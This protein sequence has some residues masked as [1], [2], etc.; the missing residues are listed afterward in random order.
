MVDTTLSE[1]EVDR[2][3]NAHHAHIMDFDIPIKSLVK[4]LLRAK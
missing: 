2:V 1:F 3:L 4:I